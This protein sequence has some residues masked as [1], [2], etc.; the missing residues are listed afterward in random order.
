MNGALRSFH[1]LTRFKLI[2]SPKKHPSPVKPQSDLTGNRLRTVCVIYRHRT[3][4]TNNS[5]PKMKILVTGGAGYIGS[6]TTENLIAQGHEVVPSAPL[7]V[8]P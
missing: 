4:D 7:V 1:R 2:R 6:V 3:F 8:V 5:N